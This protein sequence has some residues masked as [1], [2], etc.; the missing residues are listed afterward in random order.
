MRRFAVV[1]ML[2]VLACNDEQLPSD[3]PGSA[4]YNDA[5]IA[6][7]M[8]GCYEFDHDEGRRMSKDITAFELR[9]R[10]LRIVD[11]QQHYA[12]YVDGHPI[13]YAEW[14]PLLGSALRVTIARDPG[15]GVML[16]TL[17]RSAGKVKGTYQE[18]GD[19]PTELIGYPLKVRKITCAPV[20]N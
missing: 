12:V 17:W 5:P 15:A 8:T 19:I 6:T 3:P 9:A 16:F 11:G 7:W 10:P 14:W 18:M 2:L 4:R 13:R 20:H 1:A